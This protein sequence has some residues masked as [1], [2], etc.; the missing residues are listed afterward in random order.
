[1]NK[2]ILITKIIIKLKLN[3]NKMLFT[4]KITNWSPT[5][6]RRYSFHFGTKL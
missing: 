6:T 2:L 3:K 4:K 1:M 5:M